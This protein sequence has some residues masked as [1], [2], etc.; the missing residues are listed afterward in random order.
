M[1]E[2]ITLISSQIK[3]KQNTNGKASPLHTLPSA[4]L[5]DVILTVVDHIGTVV[6]R[7]VQRN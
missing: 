3:V 6:L 7:P 2:K 5:L 4:V 1:K